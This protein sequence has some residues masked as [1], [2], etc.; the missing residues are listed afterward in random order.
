[1][2]KTIS[3]LVVVLIAVLTISLTASANEVTYTVKNNV[4]RE[5]KLSNGSIR[6]LVV[7]DYGTWLPNDDAYIRAEA[8]GPGSKNVEA[9]AKSGTKNVTVSDSATVNKNIKVVAQLSGV[10]YFQN[11][12]GIAKSSVGKVTVNVVE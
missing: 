10:D 4:K 12:Y 3:S 6:S 2:K 5:Y 7:S 1:M 8:N 11:G 9:Y